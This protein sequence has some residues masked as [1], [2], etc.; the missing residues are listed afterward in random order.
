[1]GIKANGPL[2]NYLFI[3]V[4]LHVPQSYRWL[5]GFAVQALIDFLSVAYWPIWV[6][7]AFMFVVALTFQIQGRVPNALTFFGIA[8][9]WLV[10]VV[11]ECAPGLLP[12]TGG[13]ILPSLAAT[14]VCLVLQLKAYKIGLGAGCL[15]AQMVFGA[16]IGCALPLEP[17][18]LVSAF[19]T[20]F[21]G[22]TLAVL[23]IIA[24]RM[25]GL[26]LSELLLSRPQPQDDLEEEGFA[27][28]QAPQVSIGPNQFFPAQLPLAFGSIAGVLLFF[29]LNAQGPKPLGLKPRP[30]PAQV[31]GF[32]K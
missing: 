14:V 19:A 22:A 16:W 17:A 26:R 25:N 20:L 4:L 11:I 6:G 29:V 32:N 30:A 23:W 8:T 5:W 9:G 18:L 12:A 27:D 2:S 28:Y 3:G 24:A 13:G 21:G 1:M 15:K 10:A 7:F 31:V